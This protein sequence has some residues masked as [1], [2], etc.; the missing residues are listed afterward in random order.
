MERRIV[1][2][3]IPL[4]LPSLNEYINECRRNRFAGA[5]MKRQIERSLGWYINTLPVF[6]K[7]VKIHFHWFEGNK[8]R[9]VDNVAFAKKFI[10]DSM[11]KCGKIKDDNRNFVKSFTDDFTYCKEFKIILEVE[12]LEE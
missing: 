9:D 1:K 2:L 10:L 4:K 6:D 8:R 3:E 11:V 12:E 7:P 5:N